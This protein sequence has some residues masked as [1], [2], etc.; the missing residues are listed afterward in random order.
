MKLPDP[1]QAAS[2]FL[3]RA[4]QNC[5][6]VDLDQIAALWLGLK[7]STDNLEREGY[8]VD[9]GAQGAEIIV[10]AEEPLPRRRYTIAHE[11]GHWVLQCSAPLSYD[12]G[13]VVPQAITHSL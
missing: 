5:P 7:I 1:E 9:L 10:R 2:E 11:L 3:D 13:I 8:L 6:P 4:S 12:P